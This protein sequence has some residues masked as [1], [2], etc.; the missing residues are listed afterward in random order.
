MILEREGFTKSNLHFCGIVDEQK[1]D[2]SHWSKK[3]DWVKKLRGRQ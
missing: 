2:E 1:R 3:L